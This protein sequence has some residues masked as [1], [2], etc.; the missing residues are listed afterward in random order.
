MWGPLLRPRFLQQLSTMGS[1]RSDLG[2]RRA[3]P[4]TFPHSLCCFALSL[5][6]ISQGCLRRWNWRELAV[7]GVGQPRPLLTDQPPAS[8][9]P[10]KPKPHKNRHFYV[11]VPALLHGCE[12]ISQEKET[13]TK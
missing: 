5:N 11:D 8:S 1:P 3:D 7:S 13:L 4:H 6:V 12:S 2:A 10:R 9:S